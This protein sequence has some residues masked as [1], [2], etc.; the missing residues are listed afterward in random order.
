MARRAVPGHFPAVIEH[1]AGSGGSGPAGEHPD[2]VGVG[3]C[4]EVA[5]DDNRIAARSDLPHE[6][7]QLTHLALADSTGVQRVVKHHRKQLDGP[8]LTV[9]GDMH[10]LAS[11]DASFGA[12][13]AT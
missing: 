1:H 10:D 4:V 8:A 7:D 13:C 11:A 12:Q 5:A 3:T 2:L 6:L 9:D